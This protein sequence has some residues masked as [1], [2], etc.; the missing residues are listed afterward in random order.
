MESAKT[1]H[2]TKLFLQTDL[3]YVASELPHVWAGKL[4][5]DQGLANQQVF[6]GKTCLEQ[7][8][9]GRRLYFFPLGNQCRGMDCISDK[10]RFSAL[11]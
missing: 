4:D 10:Q 8:K 7:V 2:E 1:Y 6:A 11:V 3:C 9:R 5:A